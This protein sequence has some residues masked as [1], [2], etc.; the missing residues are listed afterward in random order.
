MKTTAH[1]QCFTVGDLR[2]ASDREAALRMAYETAYEELSKAGP[3]PDDA[4][5]CI[6]I[7]YLKEN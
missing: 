2:S 7:E 3:I 6:R 4:F 1:T 5:V